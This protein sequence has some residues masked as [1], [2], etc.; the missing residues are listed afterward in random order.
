M[1]RNMIATV[2]PAIWTRIGRWHESWVKGLSRRARIANGIGTGDDLQNWVGA[3]STDRVVSTKK[4]IVFAD[5]PRFQYLSPFKHVDFHRTLERIYSWS[6]SLAG[7]RPSFVNTWGDALHAIYDSPTQG[8]AFSLAFVEAAAKVNWQYLGLSADT[9]FRVGIHYG[10]VQM[11]RDKILGH[12]LFVGCAVTLAAR[13]EPTA[14]PG[15]IL[16]SGTFAEALNSSGRGRFQC[17]YVGERYLS[18]T[19]EK[20]PAYQLSRKDARL[21]A[22]G[23]IGDSPQG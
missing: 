14:I 19:E 13:I 5:L 9:N 7:G 17:V 18:K 4:T 22:G 3:I 15:Q 11:H 8:A 21:I 10:R 12:N 6:A 16:T 2:H 23:P 1:G 20:Y